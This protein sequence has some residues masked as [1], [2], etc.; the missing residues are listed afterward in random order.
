MHRARP[1][2]IRWLIAVMVI[3]SFG[4]A[5]AETSALNNL[6]PSLKGKVVLLDFWASWCGPC[7]QSFPWMNDL[8]QRYGKDGLVIV[9]VN[10]DQDRELAQQF[11]AQVPAKFRIAY[12]PKGDLATQLDVSTMPSSFVIDRHG[13]I[14]ERHKGFREGQRQAREQSLAQLLKE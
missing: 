1:L 9:A 10:M 6:L 7:R 5:H 11:L 14:R 12:D 8:E 4:V 2:F 3:S 13:Q